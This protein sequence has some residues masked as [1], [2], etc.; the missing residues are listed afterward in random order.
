MAA[1]KVE[2]GVCKKAADV[3]Y[4]AVDT[5]IGEEAFNAA[6]KDTCYDYYGL[7]G[8]WACPADL[9]TVYVNWD[10]G[11]PQHGT[12][13]KPV[14]TVTAGKETVASGGTVIIAAGSYPESIV[15]SKSMTLEASGGSVVIG[16]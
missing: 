9:T 7:G 3:F 10:A 16:E 2:F 1:A 4:A 6:K 14:L 11:C 12:V 8:E 5:Q 13:D 15:I